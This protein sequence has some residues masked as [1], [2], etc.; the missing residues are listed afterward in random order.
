MSSHNVR[1]IAGVTILAIVAAGFIPITEHQWLSWGRPLVMVA[2]VF[3]GACLGA[4]IIGNPT[5]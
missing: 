4:I 1:L 2:G 5:K 3:L